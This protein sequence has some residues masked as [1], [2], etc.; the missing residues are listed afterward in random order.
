M[1]AFPM[2]GISAKT[3]PFSGTI[4]NSVPLGNAVP[5]ADGQTIEFADFRAINVENISNGSG[6]NDAR[7][8]A[9]QTLKEAFDERLGSGAKT[10]KPLDLH[11]VGPSVQYKVRGKDGQAREYATVGAA[12]AAGVAAIVAAAVWAMTGAETP[13]KSTVATKAKAFKV[14]LISSS[15]YIFSADLLLSPFLRTAHLLER[16]LRVKKGSA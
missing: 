6:A 4:G 11:N 7:G 2:S 16:L 12:V 10:S 5:G 3:A 14:L 13:I 9:H 1:T 8:V 15:R